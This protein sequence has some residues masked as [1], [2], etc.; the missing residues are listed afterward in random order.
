[1]RLGVVMTG[2]GA[3]AAACV[4]VMKELTRRGI[5]PC[6]VC[7]MLGGAWPA[8]LFAVGMDEAGMEKA[9]HQAAALGRRMIAPVWYERLLGEHMPAGVHLNKLLS[10]QTGQHV[11]SLCPKPVVFPCRLAR[12]GHRIVF[13]TRAFLQ[14]SG[15]TLAMQATIGFAARAAMTVVPFLSPLHMM[16]SPILAESDT[17]FACRELLAL[18]AQRVLVV[19]PVSSPGRELDALEQAGAALRYA[20]GHGE[21]AGVLRVVMPE[22]AG[23][24]DF[25]RLGACSEAGESAAREK[26]DDLLGAMGVSG[27]RVLPF[28][29]YRV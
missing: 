19:N 17:E 6:S 13:S 28:R 10:A 1:M 4:G 26:L 16:G 5:A 9:L 29:R 25:A 3:H 22:R 27:S 8:A 18:G 20:G 2:M 12:S 7:G 23:A 14:E 21:R 15:A 11:L 24:L